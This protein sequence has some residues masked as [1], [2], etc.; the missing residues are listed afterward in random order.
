M[1]GQPGFLDADERLRALS[2]A[3]DPLERLERVREGRRTQLAGMQP[4][5]RAPPLRRQRRGVGLRR[6]VPQPAARGRRPAPARAARAREVFSAPRWLVRAGGAPWRPPLPRDFPPRGIV[7]RQT[8]CRLAAAGV[9]GDGPRRPA[10]P[11]APLRRP[12]AAPPGG[13]PRAP[14]APAGGWSSAP[15][16]GRRAAG[17]WPRTTGGCPRPSPACC[18]GSPSFASWCIKPCPYSPQVP[19]TL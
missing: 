19:D 12:Q 9:R 11:A 13:D 14:A 1:A 2:A 6:A 8:P 15:S 7:H 5:A 3:G 16:P 17:G 10:R 4:R 18:T